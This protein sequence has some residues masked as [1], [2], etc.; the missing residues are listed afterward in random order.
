[1]CFVFSQRKVSK[2]H[3]AWVPKLLH[4]CSC[5]RILKI[6]R[7]GT[8][9]VWLINQHLCVQQRMY[10][11]FQT[12]ERGHKNIV[13]F[14]QADSHPSRFLKHTRSHTS[15]PLGMVERVMLISMAL[16]NRPPLPRDLSIKHLQPWP[17][18]FTEI[19]HMPHSFPCQNQEI[20]PNSLQDVF[21]QR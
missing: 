3:L 1:M 13:W 10:C 11:R 4:G 7:V 18:H 12:P 8:R 6:L 15:A 9:E 16:N 19:S 20:Y 2:C 14:K 21:L 17:H 5:K